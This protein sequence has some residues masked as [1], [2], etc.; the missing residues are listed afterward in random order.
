MTASTTTAPATRTSGW[1]SLAVFVVGCE[2]VGALGVPFTDT[3]PGS[4]YD[5][6]DKPPFNPPGWV[7]GPVWTTLY[8]L[9]GVA[10]WLVW[11][12]N[13]HPGR[14]PALVA[15]GVQLALNAL[16]TPIFFGAE[17]PGWAL[18]EIAAMLVAAVVTLVLFHRVRPTAAWLFAPYVGWITFATVLTASICVLNA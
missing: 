3:D 18:I 14:R 10:A 7:F 13:D 6:V 17:R 8:A 16:W 4:W 1:L 9:I 5:T 15:F 12:E 11:R 2:L